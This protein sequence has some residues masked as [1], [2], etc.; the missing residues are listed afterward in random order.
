MIET[1]EHWLS[2]KQTN[3]N[4]NTHIDYSYI[5]GSLEQQINVFQMCSMLEEERE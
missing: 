3:G 5:Y 4:M 2:C 1:Q